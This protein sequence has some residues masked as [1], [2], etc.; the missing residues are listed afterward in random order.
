M[1]DLHERLSEYS[2]G[3]GVTRETELRLESE[4]LKAVPFLPSLVQ[5]GELGFDV[6]F[7]RPGAALLLQFKLGQLLTRYRRSSQ[8]APVPVLER[9]FWRFSIDTAEPDGQFEALLKA[10]RDGAEVYYAAPRFSDWAHYA[11]LF[12]QR[13]VVEHSLLVRPSWIRSA[14]DGAAAPDGP[15]R[16][17]Y[18][19][20]RA[21]V[22]SEPSSIPQMDGDDA[23][24]KVA[25]LVRGRR[26]PAA[27][28][29]ER[30]L[31]G[32]D[33]RA[34][35]R[36]VREGMANA[37]GTD[38]GGD[39]LRVPAGYARAQRRRRLSALVARARSREQAVAAAIGTELWTLGIQLVIALE[40]Q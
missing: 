34:S 36:R 26:E 31:A 3:Y 28:V 18:D 11:T 40:D 6:A 27:A 24:A 4:G 38:A 7:D 20:Y 12:E 30:M 19:R 23:V 14:L 22:C 21:Y 16:I 13:G 32:L 5:E 15:H 29:L 35:V 2:Y 1:V 39:G 33:D 17:V 25:A 10:E 37:D 8:G 9:P